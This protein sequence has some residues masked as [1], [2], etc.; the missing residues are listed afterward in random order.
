MYGRMRYV[1]R[2]DPTTPFKGITAIRQGEIMG[3]RWGV[4]LIL[5]E[6]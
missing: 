5:R 3:R 2:I 4:S 6:S 1:C